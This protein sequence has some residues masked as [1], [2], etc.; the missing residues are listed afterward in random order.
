MDA[1][2]APCPG[3]PEL[4][5]FLLGRCADDRQALLEAHVAGC[6]ACGRALHRLGA[7]DRLVAD[8]RR[9]AAAP[10]RAPPVLARLIAAL[11]GCGGACTCPTARQGP[12]P[13]L[14]L[15]SGASDTEPGYPSLAPPQAPGELG[16]LGPYRVLKLLGAGG[17]GLVFQAQDVQRG[18]L[19]AL[20]VLRPRT[21]PGKAAEVRLL[22]EG[23][24]AA[25]V[26]HKHVVAIYRAGRHEGV[27]FV[28][29][30]LLEGTSLAALLHGPRA[31][32]QER[33]V[34][35]GIQIAEGLA[36]VHDRGLVHRDIKPDNLWVEPVR[37]GRV[38]ILDFGLARPSGGAAGEQ[39]APD[40]TIEGTPAFM[41][42][43]QARGEPADHRS[44][45]F[46]LGCV[47]YRMVVGALPFEG[48]DVV[49]TLTAVSLQDAKAPGQLDAR[50][51]RPLSDL[52]VRL[53]E[54]D[55]AARPQS[56]REVV[57]RLRR[58][59]RDLR[60]PALVRAGPGR[61]RADRRC[62][63][64]RASD[65]SPPGLH[66]SGKNPDEADSGGRI[67]VVNHKMV[68][69]GD[70]QGD[71]RV[72]VKRQHGGAGDAGKAP[73]QGRHTAGGGVRAGPLQE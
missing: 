49:A 39:P 73:R 54:K 57:K 25:R 16:R 17:M 51:A 59:E 69:V 21:S 42:A 56:A 47:L 6:E 45:L 72:K 66:G 36:A 37:G 5:A 7:A 68:R 13:T 24:T 31:L 1:G 8:L 71:L 4:E 61:E 2:T 29:M 55:P 11:K 62:P 46:S 53:L 34:Q 40:G 67:A 48:P 23:R 41:S 28:A 14:P 64:V 27:P 33:A 26:R 44:D 65:S 30:E 50:I 38:K 12:G 60:R 63:P 70:L 15:S 32:P 3:P 35:L 22:R 10:V 20:K 58:I 18:R 19:V 9:V 52:I 43:E